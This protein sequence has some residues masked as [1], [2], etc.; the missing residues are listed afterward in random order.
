METGHMKWVYKFPKLSVHV[1]APTVLGNGLSLPVQES[2][3]LHLVCVA[4]SNPP[5]RLSW[6]RGSLTLSPSQPSDLGV[7]ELLRVHTG[8]EGEFTCWAENLQGTQHTSVSLSL[9]RRGRT[10]ECGSWGYPVYTPLSCWKPGPVPEVVAVA[11]G[12]A[13]VKTLLLGLCL[14]SACL[15]EISGAL[16]PRKREQ[17]PNLPAAL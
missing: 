5:A 3:S 14:A 6:A 16:Q 2:Q 12:A 10:Q 4:D 11:V 17:G 13:A 7:L 15:G 1:T 8:Y 9:Q